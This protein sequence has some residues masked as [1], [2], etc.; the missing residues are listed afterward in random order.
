MMKSLCGVIAIA[1][2]SLVM[3]CGGSSD[4]GNSSGGSINTADFVGGCTTMTAGQTTCLEEYSGTTS[5]MQ[6]SCGVVGGSYSANH[7]SATSCVGK[8]TNVSAQKIDYYYQDP[9]NS[10]ADCAHTSG[11]TW[12]T[13]CQ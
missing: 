5:S 8:C 9:T 12:S 10:Q 4:N 6:T 13:S 1:L 7:C 3:A 2:A 11:T